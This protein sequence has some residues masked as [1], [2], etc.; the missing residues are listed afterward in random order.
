MLIFSRLSFH[1]NIILKERAC[2]FE[3]KIY[4]SRIRVFHS[5]KKMIGENKSIWDIL[6]ELYDNDSINLNE[7]LLEFK[8]MYLLII[9]FLR[10]SKIHQLQW[11]TKLGR[12]D[13]MDVGIYCGSMW[14]VKG[15]MIGALSKHS[16]I[17]CRPKTSIIPHF[18][19]QHFQSKLSCIVSIRTGQT[20]H[21]LYKTLKKFEPKKMH[22]FN[23]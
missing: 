16:Y 11:Q 2:I 17:M 8:Y 3:I 7:L 18:Q 10:K 22:L 19:K 9:N 12:R 6:E 1:I 5:N 4:L 20:I 13:A 21:I 15:L 23:E 14:M